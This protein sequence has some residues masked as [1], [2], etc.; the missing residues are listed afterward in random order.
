VFMDPLSPLPPLPAHLAPFVND[1]PVGALFPNINTSVFLPDTIAPSP[2]LLLPSGTFPNP[3]RIGSRGSFKV[4]SL[5]NIELTGPYMHNGGILTL[6]QLIDFYARGGDFPITNESERDPLIRDLHVEFETFLTESDKAAL[7][8]FLLAMTDERVKYAR[9]PFDHPEIIV[10]LDGTAPDNTGG[11]DVLLSDARFLHVEAVGAAGRATPLPNYLGISSIEG[12]PGL[13]HFDVVT[14]EPAPP[15]PPTPVLALSPITPG[16]VGIQNTVSVSGATPGGFVAL[17]IARSAG[18]TVIGLSTCIDG[19]QTGLSQP[20]VIF[21]A[22]TPDG[23][24]DFKATPPYS[25][26]GTTLHFQA[27]DVASCG[28]TNVVTH[29]F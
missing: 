22:M 9:A 23:N 28:V 29:T 27:I 21:I 2:F 11:R 3:N 18:S 25:F 12:Q 7:V 26:A 10:P 15:P 1:F 17:A 6:R 13:D 16:F 19:I 14:G 5:K 20:R 4:P 8:D 24:L